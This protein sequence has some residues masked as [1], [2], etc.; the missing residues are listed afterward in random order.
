M[1]RPLSDVSNIDLQNEILPRMDRS[2]I[3]QIHQTLPTNLLA[4]DFDAF[5]PVFLGFRPE[6]LEDKYPGDY[7]L[8]SGVDF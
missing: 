1:R 5:Q 7:L 8:V 3:D 6:Q 2:I 4:E